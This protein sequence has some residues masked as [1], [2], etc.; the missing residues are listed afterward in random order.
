MTP[1]P[2]RVHFSPRS[3]FGDELQERAH[4]YFEDAGR[5]RRGGLRMLAKSGVIL[6]W[7]AAS[8]S[9][10]MFASPAPWAA[11]L[12]AVSLG[13]ALAGVGFSVMHDANHGSYSERPWVNRLMS[14]SL[15]L[16]G[17]S[18]FLWRMKHNVLHHTY[19]NVHG[20]DADLEVGEP[21]LRFAPWQARRPWHRFQHLYVW[22]L[23]A[24][25]PWNWLLVED[26]RELA[27][28]LVAGQQGAPVRGRP[29]W[30]AL[31]GKLVFVTWAIVLPVW[32][33]PTWAL[34]PLAVVAMGTLGIVLAVVFQLAHCVGEA[35]VAEPGAVQGGWAE[36]QLST[37]VDFD[38][39]NRV[40]SWYVGG[41]N[42]QVEH[43]LFPKVSH[44]HYPALSAIV[45]ETARRH[46]LAYRCQPTLGSAIAANVRWLRTLGRGGEL[47]GRA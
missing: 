29:L 9:L 30:V 24:I 20:L 7:L 25:S 26:F 43:H 42:F 39:R 22:L 6:G 1:G 38:R 35:E 2:P 15:D 8:W 36:H 3:A 10:L 33:H 14:L 13:L 17:A 46:G 41:L 21:F 40:L 23:Y 37:T 5:S 28:G 11:G 31:A 19:T 12:L 47:L 27:T 4:A 44:L 45:E 18:S 34:V 16:I 32:L